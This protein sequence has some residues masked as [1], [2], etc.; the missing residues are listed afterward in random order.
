MAMQQKAWMTGELF[1]VWINHFKQS[2]DQNMGFSQRHLLILDG[3]GSHVSLEVVASAHEVGINI[4]TLPAH[5]SH[6]LQPLDVSVFKSLKGN[7]RKERAIWQLKTDN[8]QATKG[9]LASIAFKAITLSLAEENIKARF[10]ETGIW[11]HDANAV[12]FEGMPCNYIAMIN[13]NIQIDEVI[14]H[15]DEDVSQVPSTPN[16]ELRDL[17]TIEGDFTSSQCISITSMEGEAVHALK[18]MANVIQDIHPS[19]EETLI[20]DSFLNLTGQDLLTAFDPINAYM[21]SLPLQAGQQT[22]FQQAQHEDNPPAEHQ[23]S[24]GSDPQQEKLAQVNK[25]NEQ[26]CIVDLLRVP[27]TEVCVRNAPR[28][29]EGYTNSLIIT[30]SQYVKSMRAKNAKKEELSKAREEKRLEKDK[31]RLQS[32]ADKD[33][34]R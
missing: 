16:I 21:D 14:P 27:I 33:E 12:S 3:H 31:K 20:R 2:I 34:R 30:S 9:E 25:P 26:R 8:S 11:P 23:K 13:E 28:E 6:K 32:L 7:F 19:H 29:V 18:S 5:T 24:H 15:V 10:R 1:Q 22:D 4:V 17:S